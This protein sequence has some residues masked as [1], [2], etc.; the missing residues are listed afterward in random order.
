MNEQAEE[1]RVSREENAMRRD[2]SLARR[3]APDMAEEAPMTTANRRQQKD[4][5][6]PAC[7][8]LQR[9]HIP[10]L[11]CVTSLLASYPCLISSGYLIATS[12]DC[13]FTC[14]PPR[15]PL[16]FLLVP[17]QLTS[18]HPNHVHPRPWAARLLAY[19]H[20]ALQHSRYAPRLV[21]RLC[22]GLT[23]RQSCS[24]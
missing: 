12:H 14:K 5:H 4:E 1:R 20:D 7:L 23:S 22:V 10:L 11:R 8:R 15:P 2:S 24:I 21:V 18:I 6:A 9:V 19:P 13:I 16:Y 17:Y 3:R